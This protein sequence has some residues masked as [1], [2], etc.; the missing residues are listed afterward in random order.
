MAQLPKN[1]DVN[2]LRY[3]EL[4]SL[5]S[6][7]KTVYVNYGAEKLTMQTPVLSIPYGIGVPFVAKDEAKNGVSSAAENKYDLTLSFRG[8]DDNPKI[9]LFHDKLKEIENK[10]VDDAFTNRIAWFKDDFDG[11][12]AFVSKLFSPIIKVDK[13]KETGKAVGKYP[14]TFKAKLPYDNKTSSFTFDSYDMDNNEID[15]TEIMNKLKGA[16]TQLIVQLTGIWFAGGKYGC[17]WKIISAKMQL[18]QNSKITWIED[19]D[20]ENVVADDEDDDDDVVDSD[21]LRSLQPSQ[22]KTINTVVVEDDEEEDD[23]EEEEQ[24]EDDEESPEHVPEPPPTKPAKKAVVVEEEQPKP[25]AASA[26]K[27]PL[28]KAVK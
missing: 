5:S 8:M 14:P 4:R 17:S 11:N 7:A 24:E 26:P 6:G 23:D 3:S 12:K 2:K 20:T 10:I 22:T 16:K 27:K 21:V 15:F 19:S 9:K 13:D 1:I 25:V 18:H 28:K